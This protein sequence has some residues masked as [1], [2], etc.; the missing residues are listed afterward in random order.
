M[1]PF[2][3]TDRPDSIEKVGV[4]LQKSPFFTAS[5]QRLNVHLGWNKHQDSDQQR[6]KEPPN[7]LPQIFL[8]RACLQGI[9]AGRTRQKEEQWHVPLVHELDKDVQGGTA[10]RIDD[11]ETAQFT[12]VE[13]SCRVKGDQQQ[14]SQQPQPIQIMGTGQIGHVR[15]Q[16]SLPR[17]FAVSS[18]PQSRLYG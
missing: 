4:E 1:G 18:L 8:L 15:L 7:A 9:P 14:Y 10:F 5:L 6:H 11:I 12:F 17:L 3:M 2:E 16:R 13:D